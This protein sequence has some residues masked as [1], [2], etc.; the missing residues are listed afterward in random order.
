MEASMNRMSQVSVALVVIALLAG[1]VGD[2]YRFANVQVD[3][4]QYEELGYA[5]VE[6]GGLM[7]LNVIPTRLNDKIERA[8]DAVIDEKG[9]DELV[10]ITIQERWF[11]AWVLNGYRVT[12]KGM[13]L[14]KK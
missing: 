11:W 7:V 5:E 12:V 4:D 8:I 13:V 6:A 9:G 3:P 2:P 10:D 1:C 14:K